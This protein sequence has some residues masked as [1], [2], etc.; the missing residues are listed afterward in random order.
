MTT[1]ISSLTFSSKFSRAQAKGKNMK[2]IRLFMAISAMMLS[3]AV[4]ADDSIT[5]KGRFVNPI[6]D[7]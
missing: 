4:S 1:I 5:C 3:I 6:T 7:I 2:Y